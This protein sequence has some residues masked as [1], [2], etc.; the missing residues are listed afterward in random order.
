MKIRSN[1]TDVYLGHFF[2]TSYKST[3]YYY[4]GGL[5][6]HAIFSGEIIMLFIVFLYR[7]EFSN[8]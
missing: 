8:N 1:S 5:P 6:T 7:E 2:L 4:M 3:Y